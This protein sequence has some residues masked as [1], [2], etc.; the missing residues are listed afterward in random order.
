MSFLLSKHLKANGPW[1][2]VKLEEIKLEK[3][4]KSGKF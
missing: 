2:M 4:L 3:L 1:Q